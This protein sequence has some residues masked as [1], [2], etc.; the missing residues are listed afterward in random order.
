M[1]A[2]LGVHSTAVAFA[3]GHTGA[4]LEDMLERLDIATDFVPVQSE[5]RTN[6]S[7]VDTNRARHIKVNEAGPA[8]AVAELASMIARVSMLIKPGDWWV[9]SGSLPPNIPADIYATLIDLIQAGAAFTLVD[10]SGAALGHAL[11]AAPNLIKP[12]VDELGEIIGH[13]LV[14]DDDIKHAIQSLNQAPHCQM[15]VSMGKAGAIFQNHS[16]TRQTEFWHASGPVIIESNPIGA[17]DS[18]VAGLAW[19]L[20]QGHSLIE[21]M[22]WALACRRKHC[23]HSHRPAGCHWPQTAFRRAQ[24]CSRN[25]GLLVLRPP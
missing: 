21:A 23:K 14:S 25:R 16:A 5:T 1:L 22:P 15:V 10:A 2:A 17:G 6:V 24:R 9:L 18:M 13:P 12:N 20:S 8:I 3:G 11:A 4:Q 7:I 19:A